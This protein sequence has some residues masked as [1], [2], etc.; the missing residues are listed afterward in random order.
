MYL[1]SSTGINISKNQTKKNGTMR[2][3]NLIPQHIC[4]L[5]DI[6]YLN[7]KLNFDLKRLHYYLFTSLK[8]HVKN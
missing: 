5:P 3:I 1:K 2:L 8:K 4:T 6:Q 7:L